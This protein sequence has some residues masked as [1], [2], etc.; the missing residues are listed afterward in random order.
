MYTY[1]GSCGKT[2]VFFVVN[3]QGG[4]AISAGMIPM[5]SP[6]TSQKTEAHSDPGFPWLEDDFPLR[7]MGNS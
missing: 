2:M 3:L 4:W 5:N 6:G 1:V 7:S